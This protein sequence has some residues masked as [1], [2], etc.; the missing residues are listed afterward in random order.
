MIDN[1]K[2]DCDYLV[3]QLHMFFINKNP[4]HNR[5]IVYRNDSMYSEQETVKKQVNL[6]ESF[7]SA[8][9]LMMS[10]LRV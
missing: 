3:M 1:Y 7:I 4:Y 10:N 9:A 6:F 2:N 5:N 8:Q